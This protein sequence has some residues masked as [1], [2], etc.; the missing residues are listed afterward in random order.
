MEKL[1]R[2]VLITVYMYVVLLPVIS[3]LYSKLTLSLGCGLAY[4]YDG[5]DFVVTKKKSSVG[6]SVLISRWSSVFLSSRRH[7]LTLL[8]I[9]KGPLCLR[10]SLGPSF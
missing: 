1:L 5:R 10:S 2:D 7:L 6:L 3:L 4:P 8:F 9:K